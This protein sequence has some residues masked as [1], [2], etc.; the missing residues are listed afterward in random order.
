MPGF[1]WELGFKFMLFFYLVVDDKST[2][3]ITTESRR[4]T[5]HP[6]FVDE[7]SQSTNGETSY[8]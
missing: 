8:V 4:K 6:A 7:A 2:N 1:N 5:S 3:Q